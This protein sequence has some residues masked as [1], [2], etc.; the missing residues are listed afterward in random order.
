MFERC[1][2]LLLIACLTACAQGVSVN[3]S[4]GSAQITSTST[5]S[6]GSLAYSSLTYSAAQ[7]AGSV[8]ITVNR[9]GGSSGAVGVA[10][11]TAN[12]SAVA[13]V[14]Y[15]AAAGTLTWSDGDATAKTISVTLS[16]EAAYAGTKSFT[17]LLSA[18]TGGATVGTPSTTTVTITGTGAATTSGGSGNPAGTLLLSSSTYTLAQSA[19]PIVVSVN[20][21]GGSTGIVS[22]QYSTGGGNAVA[23]TDYTASSGTLTWVAGDTTVKSISVPVSNSTPFAGTKSFNVTLSAAT[24]GATL[25]T[26]SVATVYISGSATVSTS[27]QLGATAAARLLGQGTFGAT[28]DSVA[29]ASLTSYD[30][31]FNTQAAVPP[32]N[33]LPSIPDQN[34][35]WYPFWLKYAVTAPDQLRQR[36]AFALS[37]IMV[38]SGVDM[39][40]DSANNAMAGYY[41]ILVNNAL[42]N[43]RTLLQQVTL[44]PEM[45]MYLNMMHNDKPN[46]AT[47]VHADENYAREVMQLF[48]IGLV[49]LNLDGTPQLDGNGNAIPTY[50]QPQVTAM[51]NVFTGWGSAPVTHTG[52]DAWQYDLDRLD[53]MVAYEDHHDT[54]AKTIVGGTLVPAGGTCAADLK[55]ALDTL[56][57]HPNVGPFI[58]RQLIQR[59][60]TS[61][62]TPA[63]VQRVATVFNNDGQGVRGNLLA[64]VK[65][66]LTD[67][68]ATTTGGNTYGKLREPLLRL[69]NLWRAFNAYDSGSHFAESNVLIYSTQEFEEEPLLSPSV[70]NFYRPDYERA[71]PLT[72]AGMVV[73]EFQI[74]NE[75]TLVLT[76]N[77]LAQLSYQY[78]DSN[79]N[80]HAGPDY[81]ATG[82]LD[83]SSVLLHTAEWEPYA[84]TPATLISQMNLVLMAGQMPAAMQTTL[85][86]YVAQIP[87]NTPWSRVAEAAALITSSP[88]YAVQR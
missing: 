46:P 43:F 34:T 82:A 12:G 73:P 37:Q 26:P 6:A 59:L 75:N 14:D 32:T 31:W 15:T 53:P 19:G 84:A 55:I 44:S 21:S 9:S 13:G 74:T 22:V 33:Y 76:E 86:N 48:T 70:F 58:G 29:A 28:L 61:N 72:T 64:V 65:A 49:K 24:G 80:K 88:Q 68:E 87:A 57:N 27:Q 66:I 2:V 69:T 60:V 16:N 83:S 42:G 25:G 38:V 40:N 52:D 62:P 18:P 17:L 11:A 81:D 35:A 41:D 47:G 50:A 67:P 4:S 23:G 7:N 8:A 5:Q 1:G 85:T 51:A 77:R 71:G 45:G 20:R 3:S 54:D 39:G 63:Y 36:V 30:A 79:G 56:F 10:Y 78:V